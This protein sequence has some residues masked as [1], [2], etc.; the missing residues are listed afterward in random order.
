MNL[1]W[2][3][4]YYSFYNS[5]GQGKKEEQPHHMGTGSNGDGRTTSPIFSKLLTGENGLVSWMRILR[6]PNHRENLYM[7][8][9]SFCKL[10]LSSW[11]L[12]QARAGQ[13]SRQN[14]VKVHE[15]QQLSSG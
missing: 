11:W 6:Y 1:P 14:P 10:S 7:T 4:E 12:R 9:H 3:E 5:L 13:E 15:V 2:R 8:V